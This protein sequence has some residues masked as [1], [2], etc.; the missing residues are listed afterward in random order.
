MNID[1]CVGKKLFRTFQKC[2]NKNI[3]NDSR[4]LKNFDPDIEK[5]IK[6]MIDLCSS[7]EGNHSDVE[8]KYDFCE[9]PG[10]DY[11]NG[12]LFMSSLILR[13]IVKKLL[14]VENIILI[15]IICPG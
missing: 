1:P 3:S 2:K 12:I 14:L 8:I 11:E 4:D 6:Y 9:L 15:R 10:F 7:V 13:M 5:D